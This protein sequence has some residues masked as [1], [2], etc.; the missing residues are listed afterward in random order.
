MTEM[1]T[2]EYA[3]NGFKCKIR[4]VLITKKI[5]T[6]EK[7]IKY[8]KKKVCAIQIRTEIRVKKQKK[9]KL[10]RKP[11]KMRRKCEKKEK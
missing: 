3:V 7:M 5:T 2:I 6:V 8:A 11:I 4:E 1:N 10:E 9:H